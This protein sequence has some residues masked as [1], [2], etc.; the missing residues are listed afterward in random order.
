MIDLGTG[1]NNKMSASSFAPCLVLYNIDSLHRNWAMDDKQEV[2]PSH[3]SL[4]RLT[5]NLQLIDIIET[6]YRGASKGRG[7]VVSPKGKPVQTLPR[8]KALTLV[9][10][11][12]DPLSLLR[13]AS[14]FKQGG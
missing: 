13:H 11:L 10:R 14:A 1:N 12:L 5:S 7:L 9:T 8:S 4:A 2:A 6:V 3:I